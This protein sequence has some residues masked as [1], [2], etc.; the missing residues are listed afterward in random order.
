MSWSASFPSELHCATIR[1]AILA[2]G[3]AARTCG[4]AN[5][6]R[7]ARPYLLRH[8]AGPADDA[9]CRLEIRAGHPRRRPRVAAPATPE[10]PY[11]ALMRGWPRR[12][13]VR[14]DNHPERAAVI[15]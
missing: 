4:D 1:V 13:S 3:R 5:R 2:H 7:C 6:G 9:A 12:L 14:K 11:P 15:D 8:A 10:G